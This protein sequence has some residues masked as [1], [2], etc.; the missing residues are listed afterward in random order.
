MDVHEDE[1][2]RGVAAEPP[3]G[4]LNALQHLQDLDVGVYL[5][6]HGDE[7]FAGGCFVFYYQYF[8]AIL[9]AR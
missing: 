4:L 6:Q 5:L 3:D 8:H 7:I 1:V 9:M 2:G